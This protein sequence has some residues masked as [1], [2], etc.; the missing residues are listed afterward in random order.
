MK[1]SRLIAILLC[2]VLLLPLAACGKT[3]GSNASPAASN[4]SSGSP[5]QGGASPDTSSDPAAPAKDAINIA[6]RNDSGTL[7][8]CLMT[9][10]TF[11]AVCCI[12]ESLWDI[13][14][15]NEVIMLLAESVEHK[16][17]TEWII[18]LRQGVTFSNGNPFTADDILFSIGL[19]KEAGA[20]GG[21]RVQTVDDTK[22]KA[23]DDYTV[24][25]V[26]LD[27]AIHNWT[28][29]A[30][31]L[32]YDKESY[33]PEKANLNPIGTGPYVL[34]EYVPNSNVNLERRDDYWGTPPAAKYL[35]FKILSETSQ[36]VNALETGLVDI[37]P[38]ATED[39][40]YA[41]TLSGFNVDARYTGNYKGINFN[42]AESSAFYK[43]VDARKAVCAAV[44]PQAIID[45]VFL[46]QGIIMNAA[47]PD[48]CFDF[49]D[50]FNDMADIYKTGYNPDVAKQLAESSGLAGKTI[51][52]MTDGAA[53]SIKM[54]EIVQNMLSTIGVTVEINNYDPATVWQMLYDPAAVWDFTIGTGIAPNRRV[55][56]LLLNGVRY[57]ATM[58]APGAF[59]DNE[60]YLKLAPLCMNTVDDKERSEI[61]F[62]VL[63]RYESNVLS[64]SLCNVSYSNA[65]AKAIDLSS[66][67]Y[68]IGTGTARFVDLKFAS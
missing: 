39:V 49:E 53:E 26:L 1:K 42:F 52:L 14:E 36:R 38:I 66:V 58:S 21:P 46:G 60:E 54:A 22:T 30:M 27:S 2:L 13:T 34:K 3:Q 15:D 32:V 63:G 65:Y 47:V 48:L 40:E 4:A 57:S 33:D 55:G 18:H 19:H 24:D 28:V 44:D 10:D 6:I 68:T 12:Q 59:D 11:A 50:R 9:G 35:N 20:T 37:A 17:P 25:L 23:I 8:A 31:M 51:K 61:L 16:S 29:L 41:K 64:F 67:V 43:N 56:D 62:D 7:N 5:S 45:A